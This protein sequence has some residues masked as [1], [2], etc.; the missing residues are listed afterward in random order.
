MYELLKLITTTILLTI[1]FKLTYFIFTGMIGLPLFH[2]Q[3]HVYLSTVC[4][5]VLYHS[6]KIRHLIPRIYFFNSPFSPYF[7]YHTLRNC[8][9]IPLLP[10]WLATRKILFQSSFSQNAKNEPKLLK[11]YLHSLLQEYNNLEAEL[12][13]DDKNQKKKTS[14]TT[15]RY[16]ELMPV[17]LKI[18]ELHAKETELKEIE[19][20]LSGKDI[21]F[22]SLYLDLFS[23]RI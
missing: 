3:V 10:T 16:I 13:R 12:N 21:I 22:L 2:K 5:N 9:P 4:Q 19:E 17:A 1:L 23:K 7:K 18:R 11:M 14:Q 15:T 20:F 8:L 6:P